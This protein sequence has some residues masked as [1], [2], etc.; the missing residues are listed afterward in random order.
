MPLTTLS[1]VAGAGVIV[2]T[3]EVAPRG[4]GLWG[5][6]PE[7]GPPVRRV[8]VLPLNPSTDLGPHVGVP[9]DVGHAARPVHSCRLSVETLDDPYRLEPPDHPPAPIPLPPLWYFCPASGLPSKSVHTSTGVT[10]PPRDFSNGHLG[11]TSVP[12]R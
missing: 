1:E 10:G 4:D 8:G 3:Q 9:Q 6:G 2:A 7:P 12:G 11:L 5:E